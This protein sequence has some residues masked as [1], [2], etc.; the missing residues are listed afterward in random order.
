MNAKSNQKKKG[1]HSGTQH[2]PFICQEVLSRKFPETTLEIQRTTGEVISSY[3]L[4]ELSAGHQITPDGEL[5]YALTG[6]Q[7]SDTGI[8]RRLI[9]I[10]MREGA[11]REVGIS[12]SALPA[13]DRE[14]IAYFEDG[15]IIVRKHD[16]TRIFEKHLGQL[17]V[18]HGGPAHACALLPNRRVAISRGHRCEEQLAD[19]TVFD[20]DS[21]RE[22]H[23]VELPAATSYK[24]FAPAALRGDPRGELVAILGY[25][26]GLVLVDLAKGIDVADA[27]QP[28]PLDLA[29]G[30]PTH[31]SHH[32]YSDFAFDAEGER[33]AAAYRPGKLSVWSR[34]GGVLKREWV[35]TNPKAQRIVT[36]D[37]GTVGFFD[38]LGERAVFAIGS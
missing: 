34:S 27:Y 11:A 24:T 17:G 29:D 23:R 8:L 21:G 2:G 14:H 4:S 9:S 25:H 5:I 15:I 19:L 13:V 28:D 6:G 18:L 31:H 32:S 7:V 38:S 33:L 36:F 35:A 16:G 37:E 1:N 20:L 22:E 12:T 10:N 30:R 26:A 3:S